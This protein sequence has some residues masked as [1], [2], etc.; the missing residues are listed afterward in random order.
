MTR[1]REG[2][3]RGALG[4]SLALVLGAVLLAW[5]VRSAARDARTPVALAPVAYVGSDACRACHPVHEESWRRTFHRTM[6]QEATADSVL[7]DFS[8]VSLSVEG[9][10]SRFLREGGRFLVETRDG[11]GRM[12]QQVVARTVGSRRV[13]Q[14]LVREGDRYIRLPV[15]W[16]IEARRWFHLS[17]GFLDPDGLDFNAHRSLWDGNCIFC[18]NVKAQPGYDWA[19][20]RFDSHVAELGIA[21]EACHGPGAEHV[22]RNT[23]PVRRYYLHYSGAA[24]LSI[25]NPDRLDALPRVQVCGHCHGQRTPEPLE[26]IREFLSNGDP[27]TAGEDLAR[28]T[29]PLQRDSHLSGVD[30]SLRFWRDGTPR[31]TAY[32]YQGLLLSKDFQR[33]GLTCTHCHAMHAGD[34]RGM[35]E[36]E[37]RGPEACRSCHA[38]IV[39]RAAEHSRHRE[40]S[41]GTDCYACHMPKLVYG[42]MTVHPSHRI[43]TPDPSRAWRHEM[44][45]ACTLCH[46]DRS[47]KWAATT[48]QAQRGLS[49]REDLPEDSSFEVA[50]SLRALLAGDVV[51]RVVAASALGDARSAT[52]QPLARLW[53]VP[54]L[55]QALEDDYPAVRRV[56]WQ[57]LE[58]LVTQAGGV[59]PALAGAS[60]RLPRFDFQAPVAERAA[61]I[62]QWRAWWEKLDTR[63]I[64]RPDAAVPLDDALRPQPL[65]IEQLLRRRAA[66]PAIQI[67]E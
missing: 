36:P 13:Q 55:T 51:Q 43:Q 58:R 8:G 37:M 56:A 60:A 34:P 59:R 33:G 44:P 66:Q 54:F 7:G 40:G 24:D 23:S 18:H 6:T 22:A 52:A 16:D 17:A 31:L 28:Y 42:V 1:S 12:R 26:R 25:L 49:P 4:W 32:E 3:R 63:G 29:A 35:L 67:G 21:C 65:I 62:A 41:P 15:A 57:S 2:H 19:R 39:A 5:S 11:E 38:D 47:A 10:T 50:E 48:L 30:V 64:P 45:E 20:A 9:V 53:A 61:V 14:F 46:T 27:Y